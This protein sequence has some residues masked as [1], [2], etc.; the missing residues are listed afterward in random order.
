MEKDVQKTDVNTMN[1]KIDIDLQGMLHEIVSQY[2]K[3]E[4]YAIP[5]ISWS[6]NNML[7]R[8]GEFQFWHNHII[9]S[10]MLNTDKVSEGAIKSVIFH[11]YTHQLCRDH[12]RKFNDRMK[13]FPGYEKYQKELEDYFN[14]IEDVPDAQKTDI[15]LDASEELVFCKFPY[16]PENEDSYWQHLLYFNHYLTG[17]LSDNV[18]DE[19]CRK[20]IKQVIWVVESFKI[21][22]VVGWAINVQLY[23]SIQKMNVRG[24]GIGTLEY[25]FK[26]LQN[27]GKV[28][29]P[30]NVFE[31]LFEGESP[32]T[33]LKQGICKSSEIDSSIVKEI[34]DIV[35]S[36][37][38]DYIDVGILDNTLNE[39]PG[40]ETDN[41]SELIELA[42]GADSR[43]RRFLIMNK[44]VSIEKS[45]RTYLHRGLAFLD[46]WVFDKAL[47]DFTMALQYKKDA[48]ESIEKSEVEKYII[49]AQKAMNILN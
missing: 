13:L 44:A 35:N 11:E 27:E 48:T 30:C 4:G 49:K 47:D 8:Y 14:S 36:Y 23:P 9:V 33:L 42:N 43:D 10:N 6:K 2:G 17:F 26:Y 31:C 28:L 7:S 19:Y 39:I 34:V 12:N 46:C 32:E 41:V 18:P 38:G 3:N 21:M 1:S 24:S 16:E 22:Y 40:V 5:T 15:I 25:Q 20:P 29:L 37:S 45:Y